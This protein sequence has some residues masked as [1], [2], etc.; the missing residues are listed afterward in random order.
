MLNTQIH[1]SIFLNNLFRGLSAPDVPDLQDQSTSTSLDLDLAHSKG[2]LLTLHALFPATLLPALDLLD[3]HLVTRFILLQASPDPE[4]R[5]AA[6]SEDGE[7]RAAGAETTATSHATT[8]SPSRQNL[9]R[10]EP[11]SPSRSPSLISSAE[12][13][14]RGDPDPINE[15]VV[16]DQPTEHDHKNPKR[17]VVYY[18][19]SQ[20]QP[21]HHYHRH[22][23]ERPTSSGRGV[24]S[25]SAGGFQSDPT[26]AGAAGSKV[27]ELS[28]KYYE[29]RTRGWNCTCAAFAFAQFGAGRGVGANHG[30]EGG[31][32]RGHG[33]NL[34]S[35]EGEERG[36][37]RWAGEGGDYIMINGLGDL[38]DV[39]R[40]QELSWDREEARH[41]AQQGDD[42]H[43]DDVMRDWQEQREE[44]NVVWGGLMAQHR[45]MR[46][47]VR[48]QDMDV[49][50]PVCKHLLA[51]I[52]AESW[53]VAARLV[54]EREVSREEIAGWAAG[55]GG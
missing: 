4:P 19:Q 16:S 12:P 53:D 54:V 14:N 44:E 49:I 2:I 34:E 11:A 43:D 9:R 15:N 5:H 17:H 18:V 52:L 29:V 28:T 41:M 27:A 1:P 7:A 20:K 36:G 51:C 21:Q 55:W 6:V 10:E 50:E 37:R 39:F 46:K 30:K 32:G 24:E 47:P 23:R 8:T 48:G 42:D 25:T 31:H 3:R 40:T 33:A 26:N 38:N 45:D 22:P 35:N 13:A